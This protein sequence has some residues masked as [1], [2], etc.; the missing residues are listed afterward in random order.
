MQLV[1]L[2][3]MFPHR[4]TIFYYQNNKAKELYLLNE[5]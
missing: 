4:E 3:K 1:E 2:A 5:I